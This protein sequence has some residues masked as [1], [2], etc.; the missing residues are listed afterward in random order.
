[1]TAALA[2]AKCGARSLAV[3]ARLLARL[4]FLPWVFRPFMAFLAAVLSAGMAGAD[5]AKPPVVPDGERLLDL[6]L[7]FSRSLGAVNAVSWSPDGRRLATG[8]EDGTA[9][10]WDGQTGAEIAVLKGHAGPVQTVAWSPDGRRLATGSLDSTARIWDGQTGAEIAS[11]RGHAGSVQAVS[12]SPDGHRLATRSWDDTPRIWDSQTGAEIAVLKGHAGPVRSVAWSPDGRMLAT[13]SSDNTAR[14]WDGQTGTEISVLKG[15][16]G[17]VRS[18]AWSPDGRRLASGSSDNTARIWDGQTGDDAAVL[19]GHAGPVESVTWSPD[20]TRLA[21]GSDDHTART[22]DGQT[23]TEIA[24]LKGYAGWVQTVAWSPDGRRLITGGSDD[25]TARIWDGQTGAVIAVL[26]APAGTVRS[27]AW[28]PD[29]RRLATGLDDGTARIWDGQ[30]GA[31]TAI[32]KG[33]AGKVRSVAWS[34][35]GRRLATGSLDDTA[36]IWDSETGAEK[37][38]LKGRAWTVQ[39]V[40]W[41]PDG[42]RLATRSGGDNTARIWEEES[43]AEITVLKG[44]AR[45]VESVAWSPD[46]RRLATGSDDNTA[47]VWD[48][49]TGA[50]I[51]V[52]KGHTGWVESVAWSPDGRRIATG[53]DD[54]TARIW[55]SQTGAEITVLKGHARTVRSVAWSPDG[56]RLATGSWD[57]TARIWDGETGAEITALKGHA[58]WVESVAWSPGGDRLATGSFDGTARIWDGLTGAEIAVLKG[59]GGWVESVA[60]SPDGRRLATASRNTA[61]IWDVETG[62]SDLFLMSGD[63]ERWLGCR[64]DKGTCLRYDDGTLV[65]RLEGALLRPALPPAPAAS[66][67]FE[68]VKI[69]GSISIADG[70][71]TFRTVSIPGI[72]IGDGEQTF[73]TLKLPGAPGTD[74]EQTFETTRI[75]VRIPVADGARARISLEVRNAGGDAFGVRLRMRPTGNP[76][77]ASDPPAIYAVEGDVIP[78][79]GTGE[80]ASLTLT[81]FGTARQANQAPE[82]AELPLVIEHAHGM[83]ALA[84]F[85]AELQAPSLALKDVALLRE[86]SGYTL[87]ARAVN[88]GTLPA[89]GLTARLLGGSSNPVVIARIDPAPA[90]DGSELRF[91]VTE[92]QA[93]SISAAGT[94]DVSLETDFTRT[95]PDAPRIFHTWKITTPVSV[96]LGLLAYAMAALAAVMLTSI[97]YYGAVVFFNPLLREVSASPHGFLSARIDDLPQARRLLRAAFR[98]RSALVRANVARSRLDTAVAFVRSPAPEARARALAERLELRLDGKMQTTDKGTACIDA[99][100]SERLLLNLSRIRLAF[101]PAGAAADEILADLRR[102]FPATEPMTVIVPADRQQDAA[103][104]AIT[105]DRT[106]PAAALS[107]PA[108]TGIFL[109]PQPLTVFAQALSQQVP[110]ARLS[111]YQRGGGVSRAG[112]FFGREKE[113]ATVLNRDPANYFLVGGRQVGKSSLLK[114]L[115]RRIDARGEIDC[116]YVALSGAD[117]AAPL[118]AALGIQAATMAEIC[119]HL[120]RPESRLRYLFIDEADRFIVREARTGYRDLAMFR[121]LSEEGRVHFI[122]AGYW[123]LY[124][125]MVYEYNSPLRNFGEQIR[126]GMLD[127]AAC[128]RLA[129]EPMAALNL[130]YESPLLVT[131]IYRAT[132]G[133][134]NL[135]TI[136][137]AEIINSLAQRDRMISLA[138]VRKV[139]H[140]FALRSQLEGWNS[141]YQDDGGDGEAGSAP[142]HD[143]NDARTSRA[144]LLDRIVVYSTAH[145]DAFTFTDIQRSIAGAGLDYT[146]DEVRQSLARL[147]LAVIIDSDDG[148]HYRYC[149]PLFLELLRTEDLRQSRAA[150]IADAAGA[151]RRA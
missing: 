28:S 64:D 112:A 116:T 100:T 14:I 91:N 86:N 119:A 59:H 102:T 151:R 74:G 6:N 101:P 80:V 23:G 12:W 25:E 126:L 81:I 69:S 57:S 87:K 132:A 49:Q 88:G 33:R 53:S 146:A 128:L 124:R 9:R 4:T 22:W 35:D 141:L 89:T 139:L 90:S 122:F 44:H 63:G 71:Q 147:T 27:I 10:I 130:H 38:V 150:A 137:C 118:A 67:K 129:T 92:D 56:R 96:P 114:E 29:G 107:G 62:K 58:W 31:E 79:I 110:P 5:P 68:T 148:A 134:A 135:M 15:H 136:V 82:T 51:A 32:L 65:R 45:T 75:P 120:T 7:D 106:E 149:I 39:S 108:L 50:V 60:W 16:A 46:G 36:R 143:A 131:G 77:A 103:L 18:V 70:Q 138:L 95:G 24:L 13:G 145:A 3:P 93:A 61:R 11:L 34:P 17:P 142:D 41:S 125:T 40:A 123:D 48:S 26:K 55:D 109:S 115:K 20:G 78:K 47:R 30:T 117:L 21:T 105:A 121:R 2:G 133:R 113:L 54:N 140:G 98:L 52:L 37:A 43:G 94:V 72:Q 99:M 19:E 111:A 76:A 1:M 42:R 85:P 127:E 66:P 97:L 104:R 144:A 84:D 8:S 73:E 83:Q